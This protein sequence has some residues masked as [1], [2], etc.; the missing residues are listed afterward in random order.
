MSEY[1]TSE[2]EQLW[3]KVRRSSPNDQH[4]KTRAAQKLLEALLDLA[5]KANFDAKITEE[6]SSRVLKIE[7]SSIKNAWAAAHEDGTF[8]VGTDVH[9]KSSHFVDLEFDYVAG[10]FCS[11]P[12]RASAVVKLTKELHQILAL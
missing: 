1:D 7:V 4:T 8:T 9:P 2:A 5:K 6:G 3:A 10:V 12:K 11:G